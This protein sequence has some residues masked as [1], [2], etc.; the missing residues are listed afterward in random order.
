MYAAT[1]A[2][3]MPPFVFI[4]DPAEAIVLRDHYL[5]ALKENIRAGRLNKHTD[6]SKR[7]HPQHDV[8]L[9]LALDTE[10][11]GINVKQDIPL[12]LI[13]Y[14]PEPFTGYLSGAK[15][16]RPASFVLL[17][18]PDILEIMH[19][20]VSHK[21]ILKVGSMLTL[22]DRFM[23]SN[24]GCPLDGP[25]HE[26]MFMSWCYNENRRQHGLK[27]AM[28]DFYRFRMTD[29]KSAGKGSLDI[30]TWPFEAMLD[31]SGT[32]GV[33]SYKQWTYLV[34]KL[35]EE[36]T[37]RQGV[38]MFD[39]YL[40]QVL[41]LQDIL[42]SM[43]DRG[44]KLDMDYLD[45]MAPVIKQQSNELYSRLQQR[46][47]E[48]QVNNTGKI[49]LSSEQK[50]KQLSAAKK[51]NEIAPYIEPLNLNSSAH[52]RYFFFD[53]M[54]TPVIAMTKP[55]KTG[56]QGP[57]LDKEILKELS[58]GDFAC[59]A[60]AADLLSWRELDKLYGTYIGDTLEGDEEDVFGFAPK[61]GGLRNK[62]NPR[63]GRVHTSFKL[64]P[65]TGRLSSSGPNLMNIPSK[66]DLGK[67]IRKAFVAEEGRALIVADYSQLEMRLFA[68]F[69]E[70]S[71]PE[72]TQVMC[73]AIREGLDVHCNTAA[74]MKGV[75]YDD[76]YR[77]KKRSDEEGV[78]LTDA[79]K[80]LLTLRTAGKTIG[81]GI[82]YG[83]GPYRLSIQLGISIEEA[84]RLIE[85]FFKAYPF[86]KR[87]IEYVHTTCT[88][89][90]FVWTLMGRP[91]RLQEI[92]SKEN[93]VRA[94]AKRQSVNSII[95]G[96]AADVVNAAMVRCT[97]NKD[98][99][100]MGC[101]LL[102][103]IHDELVFEVPLCHADEAREIVESTM[104]YDRLQYGLGVDLSV[105]AHVAE[106]WG[107]AK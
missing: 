82:I 74:L 84:K 78:V 90:G 6:K 97:T 5:H 54:K 47:H 41:P 50:K 38:S 2:M 27:Q 98:L 81:F 48:L 105:T 30:R 71:A 40:D 29:F 72:H 79:E 12:V 62:I 34:D 70:Q 32:D 102:L 33:T 67:Q 51:G 35:C 77:A 10:T 63:T 103:Q 15:T 99:N 65:V 58:E 88:A 8:G 69:S 91:R 68:H 96:S 36:G 75:P 100:K 55:G 86:A 73:A 11:T 37:C 94:R 42:Y 3:N 107:D 17:C 80:E 4:S 59:A 1:H 9:V 106:N 83:M 22:F 20:V 21:N 18:E 19:P 23:M 45:Q 64:G 14:S 93:W 52:L 53:L 25:M 87:W 76:V 43:M 24:A 101:D 85:L 49:Y 56:K 89:T 28:W 26:S 61:T 66:T 31:Y 16:G 57:R 44:I 92:F 95:Q 39:V 46:W 104:S 7:L 60:M 13:L